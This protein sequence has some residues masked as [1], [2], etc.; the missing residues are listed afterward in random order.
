MASAVLSSDQDAVRVETFISAPPERVFQA[1]TDP[2]QVVQWWGQ[3]GLYRT[4]ESRVDLR[5]GGSW[6]SAGVNAEGER[7][8]VEGEYRE[9]DIPKLI[10][11]TWRKSWMPHV[12]TVVRIELTPEGSGTRVLVQHSGFAGIPDAARDHGNGWMRVLGWMQAFIEQGE[13]IDKRP[14]LTAPVG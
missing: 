2:K 7:F 9:V 10:V 14:A 1:L 6:R 11:Y 8:H 12:E 4:T 5:P 13:T 3:G